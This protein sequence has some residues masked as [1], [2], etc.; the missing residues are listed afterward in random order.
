MKLVKKMRKVF[1]FIAFVILLAI[2]ANKIS[3]ISAETYEDLEDEEQMEV[4]GERNPTFNSIDYESQDITKR[5]KTKEEMELTK[6]LPVIDPKPCNDEHPI[7]VFIHSAA[8]LSGKYFDRR[9]NSRNTWVSDVK[10]LK[11]SVYFAIAL[12]T[13][14]IIDEGL[15]K[16]SEKYGDIIQ[17]AFKDDYFNLTLK[18]ISILR[19]I[20]RKCRNAKWI[21][22]T[23]DDILVDVIQIINNLNELEDG[24]HGIIFPKEKM[25]RDTK[26]ILY[27]KQ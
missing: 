14:P 11:I 25:H 24:F 22:K 12:N 13:D 2:Y 10:K 5:V 4:I 7:A 20:D 19:W 18:A 3:L 23:D 16:E 1:N 15:R 21:V 8:R 26:S 17:F 6:A 27:C 9:M